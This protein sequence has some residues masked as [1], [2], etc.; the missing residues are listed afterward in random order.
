VILM[1]EDISDFVERGDFGSALD[2]ALRIKEPLPRLEALSYI[3]LYVEEAKYMEAVLG[4]M[5]ETVDSLKGPLEKARAL[6]LIGYTLLASGDSK[7]DYFFKKAYQLVKSIDPAL[8]RADGYGYLAYYMALSGKYSDAFYYYNV[9]YES[10]ISSS[11]PYSRILSFLYS[12]AQRIVESADKIRSPDAREFYELAAEIY[13]NIR[14]NLSA[15]ELRKK[16]SLIEAA[17]QMGSK[18]V[19]DFLERRDL[20]S[21]VFVIKYLSEEE[22]VLALLEVAYWLVLHDKKGLGNSLVEEAFRMVAE[23]KLQPDDESLRDIAFKFLK[24]GQIKDALTIAAIITNKEIASQVFAR[25]ALA[26]ARKGDKLK[27]VTVAEA[28]SNESVKKEVLK[29]IEGDE[30]VGHQ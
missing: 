27:A 4:R 28:I 11:E 13:E 29:A 25:V 6:A 5:L 20:E 8:W 15:Q 2:L 10:A 3:Y 12:L 24:I 1:M 26:Y 18:V 21:A 7:G 19:S 22:K 23:R 17:T 9:S 30:D 16:A 14:R